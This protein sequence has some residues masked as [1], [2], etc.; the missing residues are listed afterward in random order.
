MKD[1]TP[2]G[3][4]HMLSAIQVISNVDS[5]IEPLRGFLKVRNDIKYV[6]A[7]IRSGH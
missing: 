1:A 5:I 4:N 7:A 2:R 3:L 6:D